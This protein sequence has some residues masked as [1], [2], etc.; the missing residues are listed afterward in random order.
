MTPPSASSPSCCLSYRLTHRPP[1]AAPLSEMPVCQLKISQHPPSGTASD[2]TPPSASCPSCCLSYRL[3]TSPHILRLL[4]RSQPQQLQQPD[5]YGNAH[6]PDCTPDCARQVM[7]VCLFDA[8][9]LAQPLTGLRPLPAS[10][11]AACRTDSAPPQ[12]SQTPGQEPASAAAAAAVSG[13]A[14]CPVQHQSR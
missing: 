3:S 1:T 8:H 9:L 10:P 13:A 4:A 11:A 14:G 12:R 2:I 6:T 7:P 5:G